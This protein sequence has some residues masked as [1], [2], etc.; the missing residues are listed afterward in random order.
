MNFQNFITES[1]L[2]AIRAT[3]ALKIEQLL[4][5]VEDAAELYLYNNLS[6]EFCS[7]IIAGDVSDMKVIDL[8][9]KTVLNYTAVVYADNGIIN[10]TSTSISEVNGKD[11]KPVR[12]EALLKFR[13]SRLRVANKKL[14]LLLEYLEKKKSEEWAA[15][16]VASS[17]YTVL[18]SFVIKT[19]DQFQKYVHLNNS[20]TAFMALRANMTSAYENEIR[21]LMLRY[22]KFVVVLTDE[23]QFL[24]EQAIANS[25]FATGITSLSL[26]SEDE[27][28]LK[29]NDKYINNTKSECTSVAQKSL[30]KLAKMWSEEAAPLD[31]TNTVAFNDPD[32][33]EYRNDKNWGFWSTGLLN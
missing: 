13:S 28:W 21:P 20:R 3:S 30:E 18:N 26:N 6:E 19:L 29:A 9:K 12:L 22:D 5:F 27:L 31:Y 2:M 10:I 17:A 24:I 33:E 7:E 32:S 11:T 23:E 16:W 8:F 25:A 1:D 15:T 14:D 4:S